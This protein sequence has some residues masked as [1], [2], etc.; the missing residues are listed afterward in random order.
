MSSRERPIGAAKGKQSD[1]EALCQT[2]PPPKAR[3]RGPPPSPLPDPPPP[4]KGASGQQLVGGGGA[5]GVQKRGVPP[6]PVLSPLPASAEGS[7]FFCQPPSVKHELPTVNRH[8]IAEPP[9]NVDPSLVQTQ[10]H[11]RQLPFPPP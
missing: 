7:F 8:A 6:P 9:T 10:K 5:V 3:P 2:P 4:R 1:T 11:R